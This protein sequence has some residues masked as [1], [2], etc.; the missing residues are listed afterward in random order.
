MARETLLSRQSSFIASFWKDIRL[1]KARDQLVTDHLSLATALERERQ[2]HAL[3]P[4]SRN[5]AAR[6]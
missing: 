4:G 1:C 5:S 6:S 2:N 3:A